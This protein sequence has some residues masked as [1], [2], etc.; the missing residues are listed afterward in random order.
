MLALHASLRTCSIPAAAAAAAVAAA[1][2]AQEMPIFKLRVPT[3]VPGVPSELLMPQRAWR[4]KKDLN[5]QLK[6]LAALFVENFV[7]YH[8]KATPEIIQA[9]PQQPEE[10]EDE[11]ETSHLTAAESS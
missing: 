11:E 7:Q 3:A 9:G 2:A 8:D 1:A 10:G 4:D 5:R 6:K